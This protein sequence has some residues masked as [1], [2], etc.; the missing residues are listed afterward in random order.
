MS[1]K[2]VQAYIGLGSNL[3]DRQANLENAVKAIDQLPDTRVVRCS[4]W[5]ANPAVGIPGGYEFLNGAVEIETT[6]SP[7]ALLAHLQ[8][9]ETRF[10]RTR[11]LVCSPGC[12]ENRT[13]DLDILLYDEVSMH[14]EELVIPHPRIGQR[15]FVLLPL[16][17]LGVDWSRQESS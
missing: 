5:L 8:A 11:A 15:E 2:P 1:A 12:Y 14:T 3:G 16:R 17:E 10:G 4:N 13:L 7:Q 9:I 6:L